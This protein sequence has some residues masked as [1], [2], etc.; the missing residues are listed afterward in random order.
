MFAVREWS[1]S[2]LDKEYLESVCTLFYFH[3]V[4][5]HVYPSIG[6][7]L[8]YQF[9]YV[10]RFTA[11]PSIKNPHEYISELPSDL[12]TIIERP[13]QLIFL[14]PL[15]R[16]LA[17]MERIQ[18]YQCSPIKLR[19][20]RSPQIQTVPWKLYPSYLFAWLSS[21][22]RRLWLVLEAP[23]QGS[24]SRRSSN[25]TSLIV[26]ETLWVPKTIFWPKDKRR[27]RPSTLLILLL[28]SS[29]SMVQLFRMVSRKLNGVCLSSA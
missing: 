16:L 22:P 9:M 29:L 18:K 19:Y 10:I 8:W 4:Q 12:E 17:R 23:I 6:A 11:L 7:Q 24:K 15:L 13:H 1:C 14:V 2:L 26:C 25:G 28:S 21:P 27:P 3:F 5:S 20:T